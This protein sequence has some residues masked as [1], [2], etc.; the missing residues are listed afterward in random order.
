M[1]SSRSRKRSSRI[2]ST[3]SSG[4]CPGVV[5]SAYRHK[6]AI[7]TTEP[8]YELLWWNSWKLEWPVISI[9]HL[10]F[11]CGFEHIPPWVCH[12]GFHLTI[13]GSFSSQWITQ[14]KSIGFCFVSLTALLHNQPLKK[15]TV[16][17]FRLGTRV[18][19]GNQSFCD[20]V[21]LLKLQ[22]EI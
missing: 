19:R 3:V 8:H 7:D 5:R 6:E 2:P 4:V 20:S 13:L 18:I 21:N 9:F 11:W 22:D 12:Y 16:K 17:R 10:D 14:C 15:Q 1:P